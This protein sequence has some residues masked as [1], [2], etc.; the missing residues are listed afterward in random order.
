MLAWATTHIRSLE[1]LATG[2]LAISVVAFTPCTFE[3]SSEKGMIILYGNRLTPPYRVEVCNDTIW[4]N[5]F[6]ARPVP[7]PSTRPPVPESAMRHH[8]AVTAIREAL[9]GLTDVA[10]LNSVAKSIAGEHDVIAAIEVFE[11]VA[12]ITWADT[13]SVEIVMLSRAGRSTSV[14]PTATDWSKRQVELA[15][16]WTEQLNQG[17]ALLLAAR[18]A[19]YS[20]PASEIE[21]E[22]SNLH[23]VK[24]QD[25]GRVEDW[26]G[27]SLP[28]TIARDIVSPIEIEAAVRV[29]K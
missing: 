10:S 1:F 27:I 16:H 29:R 22:L 13:K 14:L 5:G 19:Y 28:Y 4:V 9:R 25:I 7:L 12:R 2:F 18:G 23:L 26:R 3:A 8:A 24:G 20:L 17:M 11:N 15:L 21:A 6:Q